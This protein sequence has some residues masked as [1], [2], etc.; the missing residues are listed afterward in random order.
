MRSGGDRIL[1]RLVDCAV[2]S[3]R[4]S[5]GCSRIHVNVNVNAHSH[6]HARSRRRRSRRH[7]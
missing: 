7:P 4:H 6:G 5:N 1:R 3:H 2:N